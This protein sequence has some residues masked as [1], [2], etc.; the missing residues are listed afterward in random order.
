MILARTFVVLGLVLLVP[1]WAWVRMVRFDSKSFEI[2][3]AVAL[4][5]AISTLVSLGLL[6]AGLWSPPAV[7]LVLGLVTLASVPV[8]RRATLP[9]RKASVP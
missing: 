2:A 4:S 9:S 5:A 1:G 7:A 3:T 8:S 6:Y